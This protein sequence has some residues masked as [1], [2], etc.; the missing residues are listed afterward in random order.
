M[1]FGYP[2][3]ATNDNWLH[4]CLCA[5]IAAIHSSID[6]DN[7]YPQWPAILPNE[8]QQRLSASTGLRDHLE[9]YARV[10][11]TLSKTN[12][13]HILQAI[14]DQNKIP[15]LLSGGCDCAIIDDLPKPIQPY[16]KKLF[17]YA[18]DKLKD[19][20]V[21]DSHY[22]QIYASIPHKVCPFCGIEY[23]DAPGARREDLDHYLPKSLYPLAA[24]NLRNLV[25]MGH[26]CN[27]KY[28]LSTDLLRKSD[29]TRR[30]A[31]DPYDHTKISV[32]L[33][34]SEPF[35]GEECNL[36]KW[37]V[38]FDPDTSAATTWDEVFE[39]RARY[40]RDHLNPSYKKWLQDFR[41]WSR[42]A[43]MMGNTDALIVEALRRYETYNAECGIQD[44][45]HLKAAV[46]R[47]LR[48]HCEAGNRRLLNMIRDL[49]VI[50]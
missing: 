10:L 1:L 39:I 35:D 31:F 17:I 43:N 41:S 26:K 38:R 11:R 34:D 27:S 40:C 30:V 8:Y 12:H 23:M 7:N 15:E 16:I 25:P 14:A 20:G 46:F 42:S 37:V 3:E 36:P 48:L 49:I 13:D 32:L 28:K 9:G 29:G 2:I 22:A 47:M 5:A 45:A 21:R 4:E 33:D 6:S 24:A 18:F 19:L 50:S 44:R